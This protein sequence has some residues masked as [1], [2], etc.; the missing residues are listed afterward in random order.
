[1]ASL[2][3]AIV[4]ILE[5]D[6]AVSSGAPG[7]VW[8]NVLPPAVTFPAIRFT[9][10]SDVPVMQTDG[11]SN[12]S[13]VRM[14]IDAFSEL[15]TVS[16]AIELAITAALCPSPNVRRTVVS[17]VVD[18]ILPDTGRVRYEQNTKLYMYSRDFIVWGGPVS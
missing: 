6:P 10:V 3:E 16:K 7:G 14:Q 2:E 13:H 8:P 5:A 11:P 1:M 4:A 18:G 12:T 9:T 15:W 17:M